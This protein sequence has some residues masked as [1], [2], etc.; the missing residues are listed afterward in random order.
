MLKIR[1]TVLLLVVPFVLVS[2]VS[3]QERER[4]AAASSIQT[5]EK[6]GFQRGTETFLRCYTSARKLQDQRDAADASANAANSRTLMDLS[7]SMHQMG[8]TRTLP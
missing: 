3:A 6:M 1:K 5:C 8:A 7:R 2:C 4:R